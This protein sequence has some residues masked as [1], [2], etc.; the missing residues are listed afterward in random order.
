M[1]TEAAA[2]DTL[3]VVNVIAE[4]LLDLLPDNLDR[5]KWDS[6][7]RYFP[8]AQVDEDEPVY[9]SYGDNTTGACVLVYAPDEVEADARVIRAFGDMVDLDDGPQPNCEQY[10]PG[11]LLHKCDDHA[12][13]YESDGALGHGWECGLCGRFLQAG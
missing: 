4:G 13:P 2:G 8:P 5:E 7:T 11:V 10:V 3:F 1:R 6:Q 12:V 9:I